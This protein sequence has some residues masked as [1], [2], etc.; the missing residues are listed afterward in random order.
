MLK[1]LAAWLVTVFPVAV[2]VC[3]ILMAVSTGNSV[4]Q[5]RS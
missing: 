2:V 1:S 5:S 4:Q 3:A